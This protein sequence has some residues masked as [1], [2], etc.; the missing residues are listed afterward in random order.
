[1]FSLMI[2]KKSKKANLKI[3]N[4]KKICISA[5]F[6]I[7][8]D[9]YYYLKNLP[10]KTFT[11]INDCGVHPRA[12]LDGDRFPFSCKKY[13]CWCSFNSLHPEERSPLWGKGRKLDIEVIIIP[14]SWSRNLFLRRMNYRTFLG[15]T[16]PQIPKSAVSTKRSCHSE[17]YQRAGSNA[18][19]HREEPDLQWTYR[20]TPG[21]K[22]NLLLFSSMWWRHFLGRPYYDISLLGFSAR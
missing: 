4:H 8:T 12:I 1:M 17:T 3:T 9:G 19:G 5:E 13:R 22:V 14:H 2:T 11:S 10:G 6:Y 21:L 18:A 20:E 7:I 15:H 16:H